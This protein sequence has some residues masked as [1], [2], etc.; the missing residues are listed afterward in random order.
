MTVWCSKRLISTPV[1]EFVKIS[2]FIWL[3]RK[4]MCA[5]LKQPQ[6][7]SANDEIR[8]GSINYSDHCIRHVP[9]ING[10]AEE[11]V[12]NY[13]L[14]FLRP[15]SL[16]FRLLTC[17]FPSLP[18]AAFW[19]YFSIFT[20][21]ADSNCSNINPPAIHLSLFQ[22]IIQTNGGLINLVSWLTWIL[23]PL[24]DL[25]LYSLMSLSFSFCLGCPDLST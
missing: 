25:T 3:Q 16:D 14:L 24:P 20:C 10:R 11:S 7:W 2:R 12:F 15:L 5:N 21:L 22:S 6:D 17:H 1:E 9:Y 13:A 23:S 8:N 4:H 19:L 18:G